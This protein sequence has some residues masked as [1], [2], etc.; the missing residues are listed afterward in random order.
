MA[1]LPGFQH[2]VF[3]SYAVADNDGPYNRKRG[4]VQ[5]F[6]EQQ[7][8]ETAHVRESRPESERCMT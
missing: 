7:K 4:W 2:D 5:A 1:Y 3:I 8:L 6:Q